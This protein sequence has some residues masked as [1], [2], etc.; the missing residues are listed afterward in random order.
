LKVT[1]EG[2]LSEFAT[3][4]SDMVALSHALDLLGADDLQTLSS[5]L[6]ERAER[7]RVLLTYDEAVK[8]M[9][10][11]PIKAWSEQSPH[12]D[13]LRVRVACRVLIGEQRWHKSQI[14]DAI[15]MVAYEV[16]CHPMIARTA[17]T[18]GIKDG[19][20]ILKDKAANG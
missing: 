14:R 17:V 13:A 19:L 18:E 4:A 16:S 6:H 9:E 10:R 7:R 2:S 5:L 15:Q 8:A 11:A 12:A 3:T 1:L 20:V